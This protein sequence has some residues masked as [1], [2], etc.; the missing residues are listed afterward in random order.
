MQHEYRFTRQ[1]RPVA[2]VSK[3]WFAWSDTSGVD[4]RPGE[5]DVLILA[6][7]VV[8]DLACHNQNHRDD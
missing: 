1:G 2:L 4:V 6:G 7:T 3:Q 5:D 8:I